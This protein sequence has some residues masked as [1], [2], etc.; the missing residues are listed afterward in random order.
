MGQIMNMVGQFSLENPKTS[1][2]TNRSGVPREIGATLNLD[3]PK[4][5]PIIAY[6]HFSRPFGLE[7]TKIE[8]N[9]PPVMPNAR[10]KLV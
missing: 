7:E 8:A 3:D 10:T 9:V 2:M 1:K 6:M 4:L 5:H